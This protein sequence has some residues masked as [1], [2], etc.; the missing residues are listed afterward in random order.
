MVAERLFE[1]HEVIDLDLIPHSGASIGNVQTYATG[2]VT[3]R[4]GLHLPSDFGVQL[5]RPGSL[6]GTPADDLDPRVSL[7]H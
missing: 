4:L 5:A 2:G 3:A 1:L 7:V 6:G